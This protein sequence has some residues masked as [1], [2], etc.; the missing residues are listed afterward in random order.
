MWLTQNS[1]LEVTRSIQIDKTIFSIGLETSTS[2]FYFYLSSCFF[3]I[4]L[5]FKHWK[6][7]EII[8][9]A[10]FLLYLYS[11]LANFHQPHGVKHN[12]WANGSQIYI[13]CPVL[14]NPNSISICLLDISSCVPK[15]YCKFNVFSKEN[16]LI[17]L[18]S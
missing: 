7:P 15:V 12:L 5:V 2:R 8:L 1:A 6:G 16:T 9:Q 11:L 4:S 14:L 17:I 10:S 18:S 3:L 13:S